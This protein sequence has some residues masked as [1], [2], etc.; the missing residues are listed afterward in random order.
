LQPQEVYVMTGEEFR[1]MNDGLSQSDYYYEGISGIQLALGVLP[2][3]HYEICI[4]AYDFNTNEQIS[5]GCSISFPVGNGDAPRI[6]YPFEG[7]VIPEILET[8]PITW[9][10]PPSDP[11]QSMNYEYVVK[12]VDLSLYGDSDYEDVFLDGG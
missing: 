8:F 4:T 9:E 5:M 6:I 11:M 1:E 12:M 2:E 3:G 10:A 7:E